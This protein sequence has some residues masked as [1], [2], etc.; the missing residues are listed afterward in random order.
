MIVV[1]IHCLSVVAEIYLYKYISL[2]NQKASVAKY[3]LYYFTIA[4]RNDR[5]F[6]KLTK[7]YTDRQ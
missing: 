6:E 1:V 4:L 2:K 7:H 3:I 5:L